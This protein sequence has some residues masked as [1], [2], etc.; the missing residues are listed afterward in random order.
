MKS[1]QKL[2]KK[3]LLTLG[4]GELI[5]V[6]LTII[7]FWLVDV[8]GL[9]DF[10][11]S[12]RVI[13]GALLG[14]LVIFLNFLFLSFSVNRA[15]DL[16]LTN[17]GE[18]EMSEE[19]AA[20]FASKNTSG[21]E[22]AMTKSFIVRCASI[23]AALILAFLI[24]WFNPLATLI[25]VLCYQPILTWGNYLAEI[26]KGQKKNAEAT[27]ASAND[28]A[29]IATENSNDMTENTV[30]NA[31][32][33]A[34]ENVANNTIENESEN[35][36][37]NIRADSGE[38]TAKNTGDNTNNIT[39]NATES[40]AENFKDAK[41]EIITKNTLENTKE[42]TTAVDGIGAAEETGDAADALTDEQGE[43]S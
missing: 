41:T 14:A 42:N 21:V 28:T 20:E 12:F 25:P 13:T 33:D 10:E 39:E 19:E 34:T 16:F 17:R 2:P 30:E 1:K 35:A 6:G 40:K 37:E 22:H 38:N 5:A 4:I 32:E 29:K 18:G 9:F 8:S 24:D 31:A 36:T 15:V 23:G 43:V 11:F 26:F 7:A 27:T 3:E